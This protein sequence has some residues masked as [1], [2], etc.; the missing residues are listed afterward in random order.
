MKRI[1]I[2]TFGLMILSGVGFAQ[3]VF[4]QECRDNLGTQNTTFYQET[5]EWATFGKSI[6]PNS[7]AKSSASGL[8]GQGSRFSSPSTIDATYRFY[9][10]F[11]G[12]E[13]GTLNAV[14]FDSA[15]TWDVFITTPAAAS[16][17]ATNSIYV[18][19]YDGTTENETGNV[20]LVGF[21]DPD[22]FGPTGNKWYPLATNVPF[23]SSGGYIEVRENSP[24]GN[25]FYADSIKVLGT[26]NRSDAYANV[27][28]H[29]S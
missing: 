4:I 23:A 25:R 21:G 15:M 8:L 5:G 10:E 17:D 13:P 19:S 6:P 24:Q 29:S 2:F 12:H 20:P 7:S 9:P 14:T 26:H 11:G 3:T 18:I 27:D 22:T 16:I 1:A 28:S